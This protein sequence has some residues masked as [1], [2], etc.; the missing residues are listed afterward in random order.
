MKK[1][2]LLLFT[3]ILSILIICLIS[4]AGVYVQKLNKMENVVKGFAYSKDLKGYREVI[5]KVSDAF[6][7]LDDKE[8]VIG[9]T[10]TYSDA[11]IEQNK[12]K[13]SDEK[14][15]SDDSLTAENYEKTK[16]LIEQRL[17]DFGVEDYNISVDKDN[18]T[19]YMQIPENANTNKVVSN[20]AETGTVELKDSEDGTLLIKSENFKKATARYGSTDSGNVVAIILEFNKDGQEILQNISSNEYK[21]IE[22]KENSSET[23]NSENSEEGTSEE[24]TENS[25]TENT[26]TENAETENEEKQK[27]I[28]IYISGAKAITKS[29]DK[30]VVNGKIDDLSIGQPTTDNATLLS[31]MESASTIISILNNGPL[32]LKYEVEENQYV[33]TDISMNSIKTVIILVSVAIGILLI[34]MIIKYKA[35]G[36]L[37]CIVYAGFMAIY[38]LLLRYTNVIIS[39]EGIVGIIIIAALDYLVTMQLLKSQNDDAKEYDS[40]Y[41]KLIIKLIPALC[42]AIVFCFVKLTALK[43]IGM[44][45]FWGILLM[46]AYNRLFRHIV[47]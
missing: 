24:N 26:D 37:A 9:D 4:F 7:V 10:N 20:V 42:L 34:Y 14:I 36:I 23:D 47:D 8:N 40:K 5:L 18:G 44:V 21:T 30:P 22:K 35:K 13:K 16:K 6:K 38:L 41:L 3:K 31:Y 32:P 1:N 19:I 28:A 43:S 15:N 45:M 33:E 27:E 29:F 12:Y 39:L 25:E 17:K 46:L 11:T 2:K